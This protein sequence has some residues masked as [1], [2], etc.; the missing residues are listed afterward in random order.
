MGTLR[1]IALLL[2][3]CGVSLAMEGKKVI[4]H[5]W[6][7]RDTAYVRDHWAAMEMM[8]FD[9][10]GIG[11]A[12][13][14]T[15]PTT[16]N[17][18][19]G[20][21]LGWQSFGPTAFH[22]ADFAQ[23]ITDLQTPQWQRFTENF[24]PVAIATRD[25]DA[26]LNWFDDARWSTI[27][28]N[29]RVLLQIAH[30]GGCRG[31]LLDPEHYDYECELFNYAEH[32]AQ[33]VDRPFADYAAQARARGQQLG[34]AAKQVFPGIT[35]GMLYGWGL[36]KHEL[37]SG[38][39][40]EQGRYALLPYFLDGLLSGTDTP[41]TFFDLW[42]F[43]HA[44]RTLARFKAARAEILNVSSAGTTEPA[45][46]QQKVRAGASLR[47][48][49]N[50]PR[51]AWNWEQPA[52]NF[53]TP[54]VFQTALRAALTTSDK[55]V[56]IYSEGGPH[57]FPRNHLPAPYV[58]AI[59]VARSAPPMTSARGPWM[60]LTLVPVL[61][62]SVV[63]LRGRRRRVSDTGAM[64]V[65]MVTG[66]FPPDRGGPASYTPKMSAALTKLGHTV[67]LICLSDRLDHDDSAHPF[68]VRR[69]RRGLFWPV[70][71]ARTVWAVWAA[72]RR[73][74]V[75]FVNGLGSEAA[76]AALL[77]NRPAVYKIVGDYAWERA[78]GRGWFGGT[79]DQYQTARKPLRLRLADK[80]RT[81]PLRFAQEVIVPSDYL[82]RIVRGWGIARERIRVIRNA[83][84]APTIDADVKLPAFEG[85]TLITVCRLVPWKGVDALIRLLPELPETRLVVAGN[86]GQRAELVALARS[87]ELTE[88]VIFLGDVP[89]AQVGAYLRKADAFVLN[90]TYEGLP[91]VVLEAMAAGMPVIATDAGGTSEAV[92][93]GVTGL[94]VQVG[95]P[96]ALK[97]TIERLWADAELRARLV[98]AAS[99]RLAEEFTFDGMVA[100]TESTLRSVLAPAEAPA[101]L[102]PEVAS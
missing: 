6:N 62:G 92:I 20:N 71:I 100:A 91:H 77:A 17:G 97:K 9:G 54:P 94:L 102:A 25:Q 15:K 101:E 81:T 80:V 29:W 23:A 55:Y 39:T 53:F 79:I 99:T 26:G 78:V 31:L 82:R 4:Y 64:R 10:I 75:V 95:D 72:A 34:A 93:D 66:I 88:R 86:G 41:A 48:D 87:L 52:R 37:R 84:P 45:L 83:V 14:R 49:F 98:A 68:T 89:H 35:I 74:D 1:I 73:C 33:R 96:A 47:I 90:S 65:L 56:W 40:P 36:A 70:R 58:Q 69:L 13:D 46:Y 8:P 42:E 22:T 19:T 28:N 3:T 12:L 60:P 7:N 11:V 16:G 2:L 61:L 21:L 85:K 24:L 59:R 43:G 38:Q 50:L 18:S 57:F 44:Y 67:E 51:V 32:R 27:E 76:L 63:L 5:G 30:D